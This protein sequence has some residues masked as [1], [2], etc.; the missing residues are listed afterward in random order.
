MTLAGGFPSNRSPHIRHLELKSRIQEGLELVSAA[1]RE[2]GV[3]FFFFF[4]LKKKTLLDTNGSKQLCSSNI[5]RVLTM[6]HAFRRW[7]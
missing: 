2:F 4:T 5:Y 7:G 6:C 1:F 3:A